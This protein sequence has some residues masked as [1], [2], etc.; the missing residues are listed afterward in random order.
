[1]INLLAGF[2]EL[3]SF[4]RGQLFTVYSPD[5]AVLTSLLSDALNEG[6]PI[7]YHWLPERFYESIR[8]RPP[9]DCETSLSPTS[10]TLNERD[11][12][13][14]SSSFGVGKLSCLDTI[15]QRDRHIATFRVSSV[16]LLKKSSVLP[17][18]SVNHGSLL[19]PLPS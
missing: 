11:P 9:R 16:V 4:T 3:Q 2:C 5:F 15:H 14:L 7:R 8:Q 13:N 17:E 10:V 18:E 12:L 6:I 1:M 19:T